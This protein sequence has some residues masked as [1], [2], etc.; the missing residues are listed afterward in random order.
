MTAINTT[1]DSNGMF[2]KLSDSVGN[3]GRGFIVF[4]K[5]NPSY[6]DSISGLR[7]F[8]RRYGLYVET[9]EFTGVIHYVFVAAER[10]GD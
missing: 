5:S 7:N 10:G 3:T 6:I 2:A 4:W 9:F 8:L 1:F